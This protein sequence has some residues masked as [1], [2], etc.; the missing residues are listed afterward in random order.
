MA[1][2]ISLLLLW[3]LFC[4]GTVPCIQATGARCIWF[5]RE[6]LIKACFQRT[7]RCWELEASSRWRVLLRSLLFFPPVARC[8]FKLVP[9][10]SGSRIFSSAKK[11]QLLTVARSLAIFVGQVLRRAGVLPRVDSNHSFQP[12]FLFITPRF[13]VVFQKERTEWL[14]VRPRVLPSFFFPPPPAAGRSSSLFSLFCPGRTAPSCKGRAS[15]PG[16]AST[17]PSTASCRWCGTSRPPCGSCP[18][19]WRGCRKK[20]SCLA[21]KTWDFPRPQGFTRLFGNGLEFRVIPQTPQSQGVVG[22]HW[23]CWLMLVALFCVL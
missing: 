1:S 11:A 10:F 13:L 16:S 23:A 9:I 19:A 18:P 7:S 2:L 14:E 17:T 5:L 21:S 4:D 20:F 12:I 8:Q 6:T 22:T 15:S 3:F